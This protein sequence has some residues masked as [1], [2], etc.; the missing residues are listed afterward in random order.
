MEK[1]SSNTRYGANYGN[2]R[3]EADVNTDADN[4]VK[5]INTGIVR[6]E[7]NKVN[8]SFNVSQNGQLNL[9]GIDIADKATTDAVTAAIAEF[10][11]E[12]ITQ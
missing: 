5:S 1:I 6:D 2:L 8:A 3:V 12:A 10:Y 11:K 7:E 9:W 4:K